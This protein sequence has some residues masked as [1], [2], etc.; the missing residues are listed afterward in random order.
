MGDAHVRDP[1]GDVGG[2]PS[3]TLF[4]IDIGCI[5][6]VVSLG[7]HLVLL[8]AVEALCMVYAL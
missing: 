1:F 8:Q 2:S 4:G 5:D 3:S 6:S 7:L